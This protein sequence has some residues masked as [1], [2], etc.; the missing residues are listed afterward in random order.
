[1][2]KCAKKL[3]NEEWMR[4]AIKEAKKSFLMDEV[5]V[6]AIIVHNNKLISKG[7]NQ[8]IKRE[9][10]TAHAEIIAI[11]NASKILKNYRLIDCVIYVTLEPCIM[12]L[13]A[14]I[15]ARVKKVFFGTEQNK[16]YNVNNVINSNSR[17]N[18]IK[19]FKQY[20]IKGKILEKETSLILKNFFKKK[21]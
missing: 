8:V 15:Q 17:K 16:N 5:P 2:I 10:P 4:L 21:R 19:Y 11:R 20:D 7:N 12:C 14:I 6:G 1:M 3:K 13:G 18:C 9:D